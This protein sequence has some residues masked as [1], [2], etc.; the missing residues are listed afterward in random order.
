[1][2]KRLLRLHKS[3]IY[4]RNGIWHALLTQPNMW[5]HLFIGITAML[6]AWILHFSVIEWAVLLLVI[7]LVFI[8]EMVNTVAEIVVDIASPEFSDLA[9][10]AKDVAA[11]SVLIAACGA[12]AVGLLL[13]GTKLWPILFG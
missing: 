8:L 10:I 2:K 7:T 12:L 13:F 4:A 1:M 11:G 5:I 3:F 6:M 9:R